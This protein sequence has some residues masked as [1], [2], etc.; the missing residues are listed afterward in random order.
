MLEETAHGSTDRGICL[1]VDLDGTLVHTDL[2]LESSLVLIKNNPLLIFA[3][4]WWLFKGKA[5]L[6]E[7]IAKRVTMDMSSLPYNH[8]FLGYLKPNRL[9]GGNL[10]WLPPP[11]GCSPTRRRS[12]SAY[13]TTCS[14]TEN[15]TNLSGVDLRANAS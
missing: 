4:P 1:C 10:F 12:T 15:G 3:I 9:P 7:Q 5:Y 14:A 13:S 6:K 2:L 8:E 11:I